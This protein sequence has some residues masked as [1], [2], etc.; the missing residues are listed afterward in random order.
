MTFSA[1]SRTVGYEEMPVFEHNGSGLKSMW[2]VV[3]FS[4]IELVVG[5]RWMFGDAGDFGVFD[6]TADSMNT[7]CLAG[8]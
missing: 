5:G 3:L 2:V 4:K 1:K 7:G 8:P 6:K